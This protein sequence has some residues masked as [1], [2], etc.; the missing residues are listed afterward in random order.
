MSVNMS[1]IER[2]LAEDSSDFE[3]EAAAAGG[4]DNDDPG[5]AESELMAKIAAEI[6]GEQFEKLASDAWAMGEIMGH[7]FVDTLEKLALEPVDSTI[8]GEVNESVQ[9]DAPMKAQALEDKKDRTNPMQAVVEKMLHA[10]M[11]VGSSASGEEQPAG[12]VSSFQ[13]PA[14]PADGDVVSTSTTEMK[15]KVASD[16]QAAARELLRAYLLNR[17]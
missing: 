15:K 8:A 2:W 5:H 7:A 6:E 3:K 10:R 9:G 11:G 1:D 16:K 12:D 14:G 17:G 13:R 4:S